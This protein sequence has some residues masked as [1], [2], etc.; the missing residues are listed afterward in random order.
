MNHF[1]SHGLTHVGLVRRRNEDAFLDRPERGLW[2]VADGM[3]GHE[4]GDYASARVIAALAELEPPGEFGEVI[5]AAAGRL[6]EVDAELRARASRLGPGA[7]IASTVVVLFAD[8]REFAVLWAGD[9]RAYRWR[10]GRLRQLT[11]DHSH[12]QDLVD[13]GLLPAEA[14]ALHP[15]S[16]IV[17]QAIGAGRLEFG[18]LREALIPGDRFLLCSDGLTNMV[19]DT[20]IARE[21]AAAPP[22]IAT[23]RLRDRVLARGA[24]DNFTIIIVAVEPAARN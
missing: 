8:P 3:G 1:I 10:N 12:V 4:E 9:S 7:A 23:E 5:D 18:T 14:A 20:E 16:H 6:C 17:T 22:R 19:S 2:V 13:A 15:K 21:I 11:V 24:V